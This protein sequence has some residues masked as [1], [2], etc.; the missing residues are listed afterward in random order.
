[1]RPWETTVWKKKRAEFL[2]GKNCEWCKSTQPPLSIHHLHTFY[3]NFERGQLAYSYMNE[4]F[5]NN[6]HQDQI[7]EIK[8]IVLKKI[9][10]VYTLICPDCKERLQKRKNGFSC[11]SCSKDVEKPAKRLNKIFVHKLNK[12][13]FHEFSALHKEEIDEK[14]APILEKANREYMDFKDVIVLCKRCHMA[15]TKGYV[16]CPVC[17]INYARVGYSICRKCYLSSEEG[18]RRSEEI[19]EYER[20]DNEAMDKIELFR[21]AVI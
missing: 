10:L 21:C 19:R 17:N 20:E 7:E 9:P 8:N 5:K 4:Y 3:E 15:V 2:I 12:A 16:L 6:A 1:M 13:F 18:K 11:C 14:F